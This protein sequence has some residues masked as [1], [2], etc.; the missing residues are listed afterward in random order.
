[1]ACMAAKPIVDGIE[2]EYQGHLIVLRLNVQDRDIRPMLAKYGFQF[3]PT[4]ILFD[5][6]GDEVLRSVGAIDPR[7]VQA[8]LERLP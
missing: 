2:K 4:F 5:G 3:T 1:M 6:D 8:L 7:Q